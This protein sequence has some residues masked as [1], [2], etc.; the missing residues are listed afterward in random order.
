MF[1][2]DIPQPVRRRFHICDLLNGLNSDQIL[3]NFSQKCQRC[4]LDSRVGRCFQHLHSSYQ[5][6]QENERD[7]EHR[8]LILFE[9]TQ[10]S[11]YWT[12]RIHGR[13]TN[14]PNETRDENQV[15]RKRGGSPEIHF[16]SDGAKTVSGV[17]D[18]LSAFDLNPARPR[19]RLYTDM[20]YP[21]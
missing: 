11:R 15:S 3:Y 7:P 19:V 13:T 4:G 16:T 17:D 14:E 9:R 2:R 12:C 6:R 8:G 21:K 5:R 20:K 1:D 18:G 10:K